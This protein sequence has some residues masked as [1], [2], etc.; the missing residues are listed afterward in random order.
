M[1]RDN[2]V[3]VVANY[4]ITHPN[5][6]GAQV[7]K[8]MKCSLAYAY[9]LMSK[10]K[11]RIKSFEE[12][13]DEIERGF[14]KGSSEGEVNIMVDN[15]NHPPHYKTGGI[16]VIDYIEAKNLNYHLGNVVKYISRADHKGNK[17]EDLKKAR[18]YL[19]RAINAIK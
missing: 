14:D 3:V 4:L 18:W 6:T 9:V 2:R 13:V 16:E 17:L 5:V 12:T 15:V 1:K 8:R 10:A 7:A 19:D 11:A